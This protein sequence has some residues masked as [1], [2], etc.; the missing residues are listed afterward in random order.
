M[1]SYKRLGV[2]I[3]KPPTYDID[4]QSIIEVYQLAARG[5]NY[6]EGQ[7]LPLSVRNITEVIE[8]HPVAIHRSLLDPIVFAIDDMVLAEQR[9]PKPDG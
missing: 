4:V 3:P 1:A 2:E 9:K 7:P 8:A 6:T 5:R